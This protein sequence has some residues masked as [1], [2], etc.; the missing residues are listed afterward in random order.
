MAKEV[1]VQ[2]TLEWTFDKKSWSEEVKHI[3]ELKTNSKVV[4]GYD[5]INTLFMLNDLDRPK[6]K[7]CKVISE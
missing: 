6:L 7:T 1:T 4:L 3:E 5:T 2:L